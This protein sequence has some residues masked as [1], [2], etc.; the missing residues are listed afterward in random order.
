M[1]DCVLNLRSAS[2][3]ALEVEGSQPFQSVPF[4]TGYFQFL[5]HRPQHLN[6]NRSLRRPMFQ[7][8]SEQGNWVVYTLTLHAHGSQYKHLAQ[9]GQS[10]LFR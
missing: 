10:L 2:A 4:D 6:W 1:K 8:T 7:E 3:N 5:T 9:S